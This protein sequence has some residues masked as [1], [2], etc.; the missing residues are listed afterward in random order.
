VAHAGALKA[1]SARVD[2]VGMRHH[3]APPVQPPSADPAKLFDAGHLLQTFLENTPDHVYFKDTEGRFTRLSR[4]LA[5]WMDLDDAEQALGL[6][7]FDV[8]AREHADAARTA[9]LEV[10]RTGE[11][12]V[13]LEEREVWPDG[14]A[15][16]VSTTKVPLFDRDGSVVGIFGMSRDITARKLAEV[17]EQEQNEQLAALAAELEKLSLNDELTGVHN[18]RGFEQLGGRALERARQDGV[19]VCVLFSDLDGLKAINDG[20]GHAAG[21][22]ALIHV[23]KTL[24]DAVRATD[25]VGRIGG[26]EFAAVIIGMSAAEV[27]E[28]CERVR[29]ATMASR[30]PDLTISVSIGVAAMSVDR[31]EQLYELLTIADRAMYEGRHRRRRSRAQ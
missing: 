31:T 10:M 9:E 21:D 11:Q 30:V 2:H 26:D 14:R 4:S 7:D 28:L 27:E 5:I 29:L 16:W 18:R 19:E 22:R 25:I 23:A 13:A 17:R 8:F 6:T 1:R 15:T 24:R 3:H 12:I 20:F